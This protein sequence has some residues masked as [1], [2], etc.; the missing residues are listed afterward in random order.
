M[1]ER[2]SWFKPVDYEIMIFFQ[3][4]DISASPKVIAANIGY[5]RQYTSKSCRRLLHTDLLEKGPNGLYSLS[6][7]GESF[8]KGDLEPDKIEQREDRI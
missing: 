2:V 8:L 1:V 6:D 7:E 4:H 5:D 3:D